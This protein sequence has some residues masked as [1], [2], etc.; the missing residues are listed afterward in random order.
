MV[1]VNA[2]EE[3]EKFDPLCTPDI[4]RDIRLINEW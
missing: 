4:T 3:K 1:K 2:E